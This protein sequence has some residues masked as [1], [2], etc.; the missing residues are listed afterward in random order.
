LV[1]GVKIKKKN[2]TGG[3]ASIPASKKNATM[4]VAVVTAEKEL[5]EKTGKRRVRRSGLPCRKRG[6]DNRRPRKKMENGPTYIERAR[7]ISNKEKRRALEMAKKE[8]GVTRKEN[9]Q[10]RQGERQGGR[11]QRGKEKGRPLRGRETGKT[12]VAG[13]LYSTAYEANNNL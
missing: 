7:P 10:S 4:S 3:G 9:S 8:G 12:F 13:E 1:W 2:F 11:R 6:V 5:H